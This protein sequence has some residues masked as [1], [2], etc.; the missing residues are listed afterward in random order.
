MPR[1]VITETFEALGGVARAAGQQA[2]RLPGEMLK[3]IADTV[4]A[5]QPPAA[6]QPQVATEEKKQLVVVRQNLARI[7]EQIKQARQAREQRQ[8][9]PI[10]QMKQAK[11]IEKVEQKKKESVLARLIKSR[12]GTKERILRVSG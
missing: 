5:P 10:G 9:E 2:A 3:D 6:S 11:Q 7:N 8:R 12:E 1:Q 4:I